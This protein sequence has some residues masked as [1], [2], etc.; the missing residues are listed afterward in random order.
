MRLRP[1]PRRRRSSAGVSMAADRSQFSGREGLSP[2]VDV[3]PPRMHVDHARWLQRSRAAW[4]TRAE[5][6]DARAE[7]NALAPDRGAELDRI[8]DA[9]RLNRDAR[10]LDAGCGSGQWAIALAERGARV[11]AIDLSPQMIRLARDHASARGQ[12]IE[13]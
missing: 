10:V 6:W 5:R 11:A 9:L 12:D 8:W 3:D 7:V 2:P 1:Q 4:D 13:W